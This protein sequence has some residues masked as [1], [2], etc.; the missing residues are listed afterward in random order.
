M[1][2]ASFFPHYLQ[3][4]HVQVAQ[5]LLTSIAGTLLFV[6]FVIAYRTL[7]VRKADSLFVQ[8]VD[9][10][11]EGLFTFFQG[12]DPHLSKKVVM[13]VVFLFTYILWS[14]LFGL[15]GDMF[16]LVLPWLHHYFRP[17]TSDVYFN[18]A[19]ALLCVS[20]SLAFGFRRNWLHFIEKYI[21]WK[22]FGI[23][24]KVNSITTLLLKPFDILIGLFIG[25]VEAIGEVAKVLSLSLR[26]FGNIFAWMVLLGLVIGA[27]QS[28]FHVP[29]IMPLLVFLLELL[30]S[31]IQAF[32]FSTLVL[33]YFKMAGESS[34][35]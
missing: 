22:W 23:V 28:F 1:E 18:G 12:I 25:L 9:T 6:I 4:W 27:A 30:V 13:L 26:L 21:P 11:W 35:H 2:T 3:F 14:N 17:V 16:A 29:L 24:P 20:A 34:H 8:A 10:G 7:K 31:F 19:L 33:V 32:V 5:T 15:L